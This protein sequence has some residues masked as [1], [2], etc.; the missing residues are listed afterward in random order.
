MPQDFSTWTHPTVIDDMQIANKNYKSQLKTNNK[1]KRLKTSAVPKNNTSFYL[2]PTPPPP[3]GHF[4]MDAFTVRKKRKS[5][6]SMKM[7]V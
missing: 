6:Y 5:Y 2:Q 3:T 1:I 4:K 7:D